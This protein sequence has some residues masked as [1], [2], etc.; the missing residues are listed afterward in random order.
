MSWISVH[1]TIDGPKLRDFRK[2]LRCSKFEA[3]GILVYFWFW[4]LENAEK[5][6]HLLHADKE[7]I[8]EA[9]ASHA[10][11]CR[12]PVTQI[13]DALIETGWIDKLDSGFYIHDWEMWQEQWY[14]AK[15]RRESDTRRKKEY[16]RRVAQ[17]PEYQKDGE[18]VAE[19]K[20]E[21][22]QEQKAESESKDSEQSEKQEKKAKYSDGFE[23]F[24]TSYPRKIG[25][26]EAF[27]KY[28][29]RRKDGFSDEQLELAAKNYALQCKK[30]KTEPQYTK[31]PKTFLSDALP[32]M[33][34]IPK[35]AE[36]KAPEP[37][38]GSNPFGEY[39][40]DN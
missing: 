39:G 26:G 36:V 13:V 30:M 11:G 5:D 10:T 22:S 25:K 37:E 29:T 31:H 2:K 1:N 19:E 23:A 6:G 24:W 40:G 33:D 17:M 15:E 9:L 28:S 27:R 35:E 38:P 12:T 20:E 16:R 14:K 21:I 3:T 34:Y 18:D 7:D 8:E 32:F 4:G